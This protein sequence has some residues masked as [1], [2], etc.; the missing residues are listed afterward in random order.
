VPAAGTRKTVSI[1]H[2]IHRLPAAVEDPRRRRNEVAQC[3][4]DGRPVRAAVN[5]RLGRARGVQF[6]LCVRK[7]QDLRHV[8][9]SGRSV[10]RANSD[11]HDQHLPEHQRIAD[12]VDDMEDRLVAE[13]EAKGIAGN[14]SERKQAE[15]VEP[16]DQ[17]PE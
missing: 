9:H 1:V 6:E 10:M 4:K 2:R 14:A 7:S 17:A 12:L 8:A 11:R 13:R 15:Q 3:L 5:A 16:D